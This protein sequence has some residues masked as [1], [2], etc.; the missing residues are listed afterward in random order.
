MVQWLGLHTLMAEGSN[1]IPGQGTK[2]PRA[3]H[4][5]KNRLFLLDSVAYG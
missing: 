4:Q 3:M 1:S 2:I 5:E